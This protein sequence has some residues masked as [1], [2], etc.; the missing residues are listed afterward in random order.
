MAQPAIVVNITVPQLA[1]L[2]AKMADLAPALRS[3]GAML[4][5]EARLCFVEQS[6]PY[7][8]KWRPL[9]PVTVAKR[10]KGEGSGEIQILRDTGRLMNSIAVNSSASSVEVGS[11]LVYAAI[12]QFGG[13]AGRN[14]KVSIPARPFLP[15]NGLPLEQMTELVDILTAYLMGAA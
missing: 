12:H 1:Q 3:V 9:S 5:D 7:G 10:R 6:S 2:Q 4:K 15:T 8:M 13:M 11:N 14:R